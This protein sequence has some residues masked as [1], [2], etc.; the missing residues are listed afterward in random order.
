[1]RLKSKLLLLN[2]AVVG[3]TALMLVVAVFLLVS[4]QMRKEA[5]GFLSDEF[6][7]YALKYQGSLDDQAGLR[8]EMRA[9]FT[10]ARMVYPI[11][12]RVYDQS[13]QLIVNVENAPGALLPDAETVRRALAGEQLRY[14]LAEADPG[15][16]YWCAIQQLVSPAGQV[17]AF[18]LGLRTD[19]V[20]Q[21]IRRLRNYLLAIVPGILLIGAAGAWWVAGSSLRPFERLLAKLK[22]IRSASLDQRLPVPGRADEVDRLAVAVNELLSDVSVAFALVKEFTSDAAHELRTPLAGL[23]VMLEA[24][25]GR[26]LTPQEARAVLDDAYEQTMRLRRLVDDLML[27]SRLD[28]G[29]VEGELVTLDLVEV[30]DDLQE[31]WSAAGEEKGIRIEVTRDP[32]LPVCGRALLLRRLL[33]NLVDNALRCTPRDGSIRIAAKRV[34]R[35]IE[36]T[37]SDTG[38]GIA[39]AEIPKLFNRFY[40][41]DADRDRRTGGTGLGL[42]ICVKIAEM[43]KGSL[44]VQS[45]LG[46]GSTF[47]VKL[48]VLETT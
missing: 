17:F 35:E 23:S 8:Q 3:A 30:L 46:K 47:R 41:S 6:N 15:E 34:E 25:L 45:E 27:L 43:H 22:S 21:R 4:H 5:W 36:M 40:R 2:L 42:S 1:M 9:H 29:E 38:P 12:C 32:S 28:S 20:S 14:T 39:L 11:V 26:E 19:R 16:T 37:V 33:A 48:P 13:G 31:L 44:D 18:E 10:Q 24:S 7:E